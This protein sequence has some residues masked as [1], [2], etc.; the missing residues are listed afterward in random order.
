[1]FGYNM[2][3]LA[4]LLFPVPLLFVAVN[5]ITSPLVVAIVVAVA[6]LPIIFPGKMLGRKPGT[7]YFSGALIL[8]VIGAVIGVLVSYNPLESLPLFL[9]ILGSISLMFV[10]A[11]PTLS[12][13]VI[14]KTVV[15][16]GLLFALYFTTQ[17]AHF[18]Y[19]LENGRVATIARAISSIFPAFV[20]FTPH[21]N[22]AATF[23]EGIFFLTLGL[24]HFEQKRGQL[25]VL[26]LIPVAY[27]LFIS[28]SRGAALGISLGLGL[29]AFLHAPSAW[30]PPLA[31]IGGSLLG[32]I[33]A[34]LLSTF[35]V[36]NSVVSPVVAWA[37]HG[38]GGRYALYRNSIELLRDYL[39]T[40]AGL[41]NAF[42]MVYSRYQ[43]LIDVPFLYY[44]HNLP[45]AVWL[46]QGLLGIIGLVWLVVRFVG[47]VW[48]VERYVPHNPHRR[49]FRAAWLGV[50]A[51]LTHGLFDAAQYSPDYWTMPLLFVLLGLTVVL[52]RRALRLLPDGTSG[53]NDIDI[54]W[55]LAAGAAILML[56]I[57]F[58]PKIVSQWQVNI[59]AL[60]QT[61]GEL[62]PDDRRLPRVIALARA[63]QIFEAVLSIQPENSVANRR[64]GMM[65][66]DAGEFSLAR[67]Y[68]E[69]AYRHE[70]YNQPT[71]KA[72][73]YAYLWTGDFQHAQEMFRQV[74]FRS[75]LLDELRYYSQYWASRHQDEFAAAAGQMVKRLRH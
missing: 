71:L 65:A 54:R 1:M 53:E 48:K 75:R 13:S 60:Y 24:I 16:A 30:R 45:L 50:T 44:A 12:P 3:S 62:A 37:I 14:T 32:A 38:F 51:T 10:V 19:P 39:F 57:A 35:F 49:L 25:W 9:T 61:V 4:R 59:G 63:K 8:F 26:V 41:G 23:L 11:N 73:G 29:W 74:E 27:G 6:L 31:M 43:L 66:L 70:P 22:A 34:A 69:T 5:R 58:S 36:R 7:F 56:A 40:G 15:V 42:A 67:G 52:A 72:L 17:Y 47:L 46:G 55:K 20:I 68:L 21:P 33:G 2:L 18:S 28:D 64:L